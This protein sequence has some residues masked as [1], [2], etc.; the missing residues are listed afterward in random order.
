MTQQ[1]IYKTVKNIILNTPK[2]PDS[3]GN[4]AC[5]SCIAQAV[6]ETLSQ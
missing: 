3:T 2:C 5:P 1:E 4:T 6:S